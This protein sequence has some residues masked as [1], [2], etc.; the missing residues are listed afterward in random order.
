[1]QPRLDELMR[2]LRLESKHLE[3]Q[4]KPPITSPDVVQTLDYTFSDFCP[5]GYEGDS[6]SLLLARQ[7][8]NKQNQYVV[9]HAYTDCACNEFV[10]TKL[11]QAMGYTMPGA[12]LFNLS[13]TEK[14]RCFH[15][16]YIIGIRYLNLKI[17]S[18]SYTEIRELATN[19]KEYFSFWGMYAMFGEGDSF[20]TPLAVDD[21]IYRIDTT[22]AFPISSYQLNM[23]G[24]NKELFGSNPHTIC[25][26]QL[27]SS[28]LS[29][30]LPKSS[31][32]L[33][34]KRCREKDKSCTSYFLEPFSRIQ[35]I[36]N[37]YIDS[38]LNTLCYFYPDFIGEYLKRY[39]YAVQ[40]QCAVY[41]KEA[42]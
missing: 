10:Y 30:A 3:N 33:E 12:V 14:R 5:T 38:F 23:A 4:R 39:L 40:T 34:F 42:R 35:E 24:I 37:D 13:P 22:A 8:G 32:D 19:W 29:N 1:M 2:N 11:A 41:L 16:E 18:P 7:K 6:G 28:D 26:E 15:T 36:R 21:K 20:E 31:C 25:K 17:E 27:L 9:K